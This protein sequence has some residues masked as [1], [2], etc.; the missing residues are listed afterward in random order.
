[1]VYLKEWKCKN[2]T[3]EEREIYESVMKGIKFTKL[4]IKIQ[5]PPEGFEGW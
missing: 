3:R 2:L 1:M 5:S 4:K